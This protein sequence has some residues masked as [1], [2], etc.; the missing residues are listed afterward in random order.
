MNR[1][2]RRDKDLKN[3]YLRV[4][5]EG[6]Y[7]EQYEEILLY[8]QTVPGLITFYEIEENEEK[9]LVYVLNHQSSF[10]ESLSGKRMTCEHMESFIKSLVRVMETIDEYLLEPS[11]LVVEMAYI[12]GNTK[13]WE[14]IY[15]P[16]YGEN[17]WHQMEKLSEE[18]L[19]YVDYG[20]EKAVLWAY[21]FYQK[22]HAENCFPDELMEILKLEK[23]E[24]GDSP[25]SVVREE[26]VCWE[27]EKENKVKKRS[28]T[29]NLA[30][31]LKK[32]IS[33]RKKKDKDIFGD[34][35]GEKTNLGDTCPDLREMAE[36]LNQTT[37]KN[38]NQTF[39]LI[40]MGDNG[41]PAIRV[42]YF[43]FLLGR[44]P[45]E[46]DMCLDY[47]TISRIHARLEGDGKEVRIA[48]MNSANGTSRNGECLKPGT[49]CRLYSGDILKLA[50]LEFVCQW[51]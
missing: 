50:D 48:D 34:F 46:V 24:A 5:R 32:I 45:E 12:F 19:N 49:E 47:P 10:L 21:T 22:V 7:G 11:N 33:G 29:D 8:K 18:W 41:A 25:S 4:D 9:G 3:T 6:H 27:A 17:F 15:I 23:T 40:P 14:Y 26:D 43:P 37:E 20:N 31:G 39:V 2:N 42:E 44:A 28:W 35:Y 36:V 51:C 38:K 30:K 13:G 16:G 1:E